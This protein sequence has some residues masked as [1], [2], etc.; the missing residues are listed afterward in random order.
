MTDSNPT[1]LIVDDERNLRQLLT[2]AI[3]VE[4]FAVET[5]SNGKACLG[6]CQQHLPDLILMDALM[7]EMDGFTC[8]EILQATFGDRCPP[9]LMITALADTASV[10]RAFAAGA[11]DYVT[12]P[13]HWA[14]LRR[15]VRRVLQTQLLQQQLVEALKTIE[16]LQREKPSPSKPPTDQCVAGAGIDGTT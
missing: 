10:D 14:V 11:V 12:K 9:V 7:P 3:K 8:C 16:Q 15:R 5:A 2:H 1:V 4:G 13:V 6:F